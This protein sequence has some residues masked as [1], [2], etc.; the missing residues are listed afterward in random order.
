[1]ATFTRLLLGFAKENPVYP[2]KPTREELGQL[3]APIQATLLSDHQVFQSQTVPTEGTA[4]DLAKF[5]ELFLLDLS[6]HGV[7]RFTFDWD[8]LD[9]SV[10]NRTMA[11]F[12]VKHWLYAKSQGAFKRQGINPNYATVPICI[13]LVLRWM[14]G[15]SQEIRIGRRRPEKLLLRERE[16]KKR[17]VSLYTLLYW[18]QID[19]EFLFLS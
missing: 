7:L 5:R 3:R 6:N 13:G 8:D 2:M 15:R 11:L 10:W 4:E 9:S 14:R 19:D 12:I 1:M 16:R 17:Q 18:F